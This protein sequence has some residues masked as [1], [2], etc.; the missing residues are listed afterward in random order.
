LG[1]AGFVRR[2][3]AETFEC[4]IKPVQQ[5]R[6]RIGFA[7]QTAETSF[8]LMV[9]E[10]VKRAAAENNADLVIVD[11]K[12]SPKIA[13]RNAEQ[14]IRERVDVV[15]EFQTYDNIAPILA[16]R[17]IEAK[18]PVIAIEIPHPGAVFFGAN[19]YQAGLIAGRALGR[20]A[21]GNWDG[22][23]DEVLLLEEKVAG[24]LPRLRVSGML[25]GIREM[26]PA[27]ERAIV[28]TYDGQGSFERSQTLVRNHLR[29]VLPRRTL[30]CGCNDPSALGALMAFEEA[31]LAANCFVVGQNAVPEARE[32]LRR[33]GTR[34]VGTVAYFPE[35]YGDELIP[36]AVQ[37]VAGK[38]TAPAIFVKHQLVTPGNVGTI[39]PGDCVTFSAAA[40]AVY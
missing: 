17:F 29:K 3:G 37:L 7:A 12:Y 39:Y 5:K 8:A 9:T 32:E 24:P 2:V 4:C 35:R 15:L 14:L 10:S 23:F 38:P 1:Q 13:L 16:A 20:W 22:R 28:T 25:A 27:A 34:L 36:L 19:N 11:N 6:V 18:I 33:P 26:L 31:G 40:P 30:V 21:K